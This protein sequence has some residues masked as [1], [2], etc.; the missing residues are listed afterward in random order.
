MI[1]IITS[2][3]KEKSRVLRINKDR[4]D[5]NKIAFED[6]EAK[7]PADASGNRNFFSR[8]SL[9]LSERL[10]FLFEHGEK[11]LGALE[12][13]RVG[14]FR[15]RDRSIVLVPESD[16]LG[17]RLVNSSE[18]LGKYADVVGEF[19]LLFLLSGDFFGDFLTLLGQ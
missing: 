9:A 15:F 17:E 6:H 1:S 18:S 19:V 16:L 10:G 13:L 14:V 2:Q 12:D 11:G 3:R 8:S 7:S 4:N 5:V